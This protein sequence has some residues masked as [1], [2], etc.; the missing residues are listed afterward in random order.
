MCV[1]GGVSMECLPAARAV[2]VLLRVPR[3]AG[4]CCPAGL[5][6]LLLEMAI[7]RPEELT[8]LEDPGNSPWVGSEVLHMPRVRRGVLRR[9]DAPRRAGV[10]A[11]E[12]A[13]QACVCLSGS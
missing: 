8:P 7:G 11:P 4:A 10:S 9:C 3:P 12:G 2:P 13:V 5:F 6:A 1:T